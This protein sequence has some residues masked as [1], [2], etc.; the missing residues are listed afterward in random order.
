MNAPSAH[1]EWASSMAIIPG[2][3]TTSIM[4]GTIE[5]TPA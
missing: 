3:M 1:S 5:D 2:S 4:G